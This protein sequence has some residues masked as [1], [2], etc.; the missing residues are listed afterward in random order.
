MY[1][2]KDDYSEGCHPNILRRLQ[3]SNTVQREG[4]GDDTYSIAAKKQ[5]KKLL[6]NPDAAIHFVSGGTQ[7]NLIVISSLLKPYEAVIAAAT[8]HINVHEAGAIEATGHKVCAVETTDGKL[9]AAHIQQVLDTHQDPPHMVKPKLVY[10]SNATEVGT[11][12]NLAELKALYC[13][14]Q[15]RDLLL[16]VDGAR[17]GA[18]LCALQQTLQLADMKNLC[19]VFYIGGTKNGAL[20]GEAIVLN[21]KKLYP[22]FAYNLKQKGA[23]MAKGSVLGIQFFEL[24]KDGLFFEMA[25]HAN[26]QALNLA[27]IIEQSGYKLLL[28]PLSNQIFPIF[29]DHLADFIQKKYKCYTWKK[30]GDNE[31]ALRMVCSWATTDAAVKNFAQALKDFTK[32]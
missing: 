26:T 24:F 21:N 9:T 5:L 20:L 11:V 1:S 8:G 7:A 28:P 18:A 3:E 32:D 6:Q 30:C 14:C 15:Q 16:F 25:T 19:D 10:I 31:T 4:Y 29:P 13:F 27:E 23:L 17:L 12:Y 2:F 22:D